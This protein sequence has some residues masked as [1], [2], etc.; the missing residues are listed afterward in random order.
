[1]CNPALLRRL[2]MVAVVGVLALGLSAMSVSQKRVLTWQSPKRVSVQVSASTFPA[3][4]Y[5]YP[6]SAA[7]GSN[8]VG[9]PSLAGL[10]LSNTAPS[11]S[12]AARLIDELAGSR[13]L[14]FEA[15][16]PTLWPNV[17]LHK[18]GVSGRESVSRLIVE[19][20]RNSDSEEVMKRCGSATARATWTVQA[21]PSLKNAS[22]TSSCSKDPAL[23]SYYYLIDRSHHWLVTFV[24]P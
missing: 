9:C 5:P 21:C 10:N 24:Y 15:S 1:V 23:V 6:R 2:I 4:I 7:L 17:V 22:G 12:T 11:R 3:S 14:A 19:R 13:N 20:P 16:D 8:R 18:L